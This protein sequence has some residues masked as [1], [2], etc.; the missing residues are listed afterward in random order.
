[1]SKLV[2][3]PDGQR[4]TLDKYIDEFFWEVGWVAATQ[5]LKGNAGDGDFFIRQ[6]LSFMV[7][8]TRIHL[9]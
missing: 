5:L 6:L 3:I 9:G 7:F 1:M 8:R 2:D 4:I